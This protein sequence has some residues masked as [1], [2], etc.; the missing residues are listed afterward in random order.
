[1]WPWLVNFLWNEPCLPNGVGWHNTVGKALPNQNLGEPHARISKCWENT[2]WFYLVTI[3]PLTFTST[4]AAV[5]WSTDMTFLGSYQRQQWYDFTHTINENNTTYHWQASNSLILSKVQFAWWDI[6]WLCVLRPTAF[7]LRYDDA[8]IDPTKQ[9]ELV[10]ILHDIL[11]NVLCLNL[12]SDV[13]PLFKHFYTQNATK[14]S[15]LLFCL[16]IPTAICSSWL[17]Q[18]QLARVTAK[19]LLFIQL[20]CSH[21]HW[22]LTLLH[23]IC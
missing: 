20:Y 15:I 6:M 8:F 17:G 7:K 21:L 4:L 16:S 5:Q 9:F 1:M 11:T 22:N 3:Q 12:F 13:S 23:Q 2:S 14:T 10:V 19:L 18:I